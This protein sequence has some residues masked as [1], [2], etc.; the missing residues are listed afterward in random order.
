MRISIRRA[1]RKAWQ[2]VKGGNPSPEALHDYC[3]SHRA[4][5][6]R[7]GTGVPFT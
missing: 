4:E 5:F 1:C 3:H 2:N 6:S 7:E